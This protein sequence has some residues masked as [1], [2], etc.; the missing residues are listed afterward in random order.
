MHS[1]AL[2]IL[3][4]IG[5]IEY[6]VRVYGDWAI[7]DYLCLVGMVEEEMEDFQKPRG[8]AS[9]KHKVGLVRMTKQPWQPLASSQRPRTQP[10]PQDCRGP[11]LRQ[12]IPQRGSFQ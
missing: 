8:E 12:R 3:T 5:G 10:C 4:G 6:S 11:G 2:T 1:P 9:G 7:E